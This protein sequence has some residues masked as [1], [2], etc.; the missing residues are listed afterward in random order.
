M[1][2]IRVLILCMKLVT[3]RIPP[4][5]TLENQPYAEL[6]RKLAFVGS[7]FCSVLSAFAVSGAVYFFFSEY[8][9]N[10]I[11]VIVLVIP[12]IFLLELLK[13][14]AATKCLKEVFQPNKFPVV[15]C[16]GVMFLTLLSIILSYEGNKNL[17]FEFSDR[18]VQLTMDSYTEEYKEEIIQI[19]KQIAKAR[20]TSK[21]TVDKLTDQ[22]Q[23][24]QE[25]IFDLE[26]QIRTGNRHAFEAYVIDARGWAWYIALAIFGCQALFIFC[27]SYLE[28]SDSKSNGVFEQQGRPVAEKKDTLKAELIEE[29]KPLV[30]GMVKEEVNLII[31]E[32][33]KRQSE[34][35][36]EAVKQ[37]T[38]KTA[39]QDLSQSG[40]PQKKII[41]EEKIMGEQ[42]EINHSTIKP[43]EEEN[44][45]HIGH[46]NPVIENQTTIP[47]E[48]VVINTETSESS[49]GEES[50][51][52]MVQAS[53]AAS[54][55]MSHEEGLSIKE[56]KEL[57][58]AAIKTERK[59]IS[60]AEYR[61]KQGIGK[62]ET[63]R[64]NKQKAEEKM[65]KLLQIL[66]EV[67]EMELSVDRKNK[68]KR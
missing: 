36:Q 62:P 8:I 67:E 59:K 2:G 48:D 5:S 64:Q 4:I 41:Q 24:L 1:Q 18:P 15:A 16:T 35:M 32:I 20:K 23:I 31:A 29:Y 47:T 28:Y 14:L 50:P 49:Q 17:I 26:D 22:R 55:K 21:K 43:G 27:L 39:S 68:L 44:R 65:A 46:A 42:G 37:A 19:D 45:H 57:L 11:V 56:K 58:Y 9:E 61:L 13:R 63:S 33:R 12:S 3:M 38:P 7:Y 52:S 66:E 6:K 34:R 54:K 10:T 53:R 60:T 40:E 51:G 30:R 25:R